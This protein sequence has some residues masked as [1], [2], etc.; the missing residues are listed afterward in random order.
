MTNEELQLYSSP[1]PIR[2]LVS[3][4]VMANA[5]LGQ[6]CMMN[7]AMAQMPAQGM[8]MNETPTVPMSPIHCKDCPPH[9]QK[10]QPQQTSCA[11]H[12]FSKTTNIHPTNLLS[13][14]QEGIAALP[15]PTAM[16]TTY[17]GTETQRPL[18]ESPPSLRFTDTIVLRL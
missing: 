17:A 8:E 18:T 7:I 9:S 12:C 16:R 1:M 3:V 15:I 11:G 10:K 5:I 6:F 2:I 14:L 4:A 13:G